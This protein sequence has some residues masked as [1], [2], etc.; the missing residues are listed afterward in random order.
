MKKH[1]I[2]LC[3]FI[4]VLFPSVVLAGSL[5]TSSGAIYWDT[6][7]ISGIEIEWLD[8]KSGV[9]A[10]VAEWYPPQNDKDKVEVNGWGD[11]SIDVATS[12]TGAGAKTTSGRVQ[13]DATHAIFAPGH[14]ADTLCGT[15]RRGLFR[16]KETGTISFSVDY[17]QQIEGETH[18]D[19]DYSFAFS[20]A[21]W[22]F[23]NVD[24]EEGE[25]FTDSSYLEDYAVDGEKFGPIFRN[26]TFSGSL[27]F[28]KGQ[29]GGFEIFIGT[30]TRGS[31]PIPE[32]TTM[33]LLG[34]GMIGLAG[35]GRKKFF[36]KG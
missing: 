13:A 22:D 8:Q 21:V 3:W 15:I 17:F 24:V 30:H 25:V 9:E 31:T 28:E 27:N 6:F 29:R 7:S 32:P 20:D 35:L 19:G 16:A 5:A 2:Y 33:L 36:R 26:G 12:H 1:F 18:H 34:A 14:F 23:M 11:V 4:F 10:D